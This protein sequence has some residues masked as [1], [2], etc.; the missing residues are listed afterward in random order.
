MS[1]GHTVLG[2]DKDMDRVE[3]VAPQLTHALQLD[4]TD[5][6]ALQEIGWRNFDTVVV[7]L[8]PDQEQSILVTVHMKERGVRRV[9]AKAR[10]P[11]HGKVLER[12]G[13]DRVVYPEREMG[14]RVAHRIA[15]PSIVDIIEL[16]EGLSVV[17][18][19]APKAMI[20]KTLKE[21][22]LRARHG[23][24]V[25]AVKR[26]DNLVSLVGPDSRLGKDDI[27]VVA[28]HTQDLAEFEGLLDT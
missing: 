25:L 24:T 16:S 17:E 4:A 13:A 11:M 26:G 21:L 20:G 23:V 12:V 2:V 8:G 10:S 22:E 27:M 6:K 1:L 5:E 18:C 19:V 7:S 15:S 3:N 14:V 28:G 9:V